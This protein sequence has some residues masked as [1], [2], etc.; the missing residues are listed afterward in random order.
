MNLLLSMLMMTAVPPGQP[1]QT[2]E[3][4]VGAAR[5]RHWLCEYPG[6]CTS[7]AEYT[8]EGGK[9]RKERGVYTYDAA[10]YPTLE[11]FTHGKTELSR[12][13]TTWNKDHTRAAEALN[14]EGKLFSQTMTL[15]K[16]G[17]IL[18]VRRTEGGVSSVDTWEWGKCNWPDRI[19][20][21]NADTGKVISVMKGDCRDGLTRSLSMTGYKREL[22]Y[23]DKRRL[24]QEVITIATNSY[25]V[26]MDHPRSKA[27]AIVGQRQH[28]PG[29]Q[30]TVTTWDL[31]CWQDKLK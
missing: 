28:A 19:V 3:D 29:K 25:S 13:V 31:S 2:N 27:G 7:T 4:C 22:R 26:V 17:H 1:C 9:M 20:S 30:T 15:S 12:R 11:V 24:T 18:E 10:G 5:C 16:A 6:P 14:L 21:R 8:P 23:D